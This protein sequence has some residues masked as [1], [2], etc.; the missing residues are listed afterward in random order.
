M[1]KTLGTTHFASFKIYGF[2]LLGT[3]ILLRFLILDTCFCYSFEMVDF[4]ISVWVT[5]VV[6]EGFFLRS[7]L[8]PEV[9]QQPLGQLTLT[10]F[11]FGTDE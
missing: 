4:L 5:R 1:L 7:L 2:K 6:H 10:A 11:T 3:N 9:V 8:S